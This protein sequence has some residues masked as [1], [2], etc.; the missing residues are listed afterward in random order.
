MLSGGF[1][2]GCRLLPLPTSIELSG[3]L[4]VQELLS[5]VVDEKFSGG[6]LLGFD[7]V[8]EFDTLNHVGYRRTRRRRSG[9]RRLGRR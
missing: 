3:D 2:C 1:Y 5:N 8:D 7:S 9:R 4:A 6:G